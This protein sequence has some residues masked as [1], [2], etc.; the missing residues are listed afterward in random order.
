MTRAASLDSICNGVTK[1]SGMHGGEKCLTGALAPR[2]VKLTYDAPG[3]EE[4]AVLRCGGSSIAQRGLGM[5]SCTLALLLSP[6]AVHTARGVKP[7]ISLF[8]CRGI[9]TI[10]ISRCV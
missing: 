5:S 8:Q 9:T 10:L 3:E 4:G 1:R 2:N 7:R 6:S